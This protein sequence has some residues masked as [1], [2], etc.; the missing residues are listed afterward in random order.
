MDFYDLT[1]QM[2][3]RDDLVADHARQQYERERSPLIEALPL[4]V[5]LGSLWLIAAAF[6]W[7]GRAS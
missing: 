5:A 4:I 3:A 7:I 2:R 6:S 1:D